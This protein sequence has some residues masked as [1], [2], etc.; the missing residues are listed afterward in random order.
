MGY[1]GSGWLLT[2]M[3][4]MCMHVWSGWYSCLLG[5]FKV[6][7]NILMRD[8]LRPRTLE[9]GLISGV[10][11][12]G[13]RQWMRWDG[14]GC[15]TYLLFYT[16]SCLAQQYWQSSI[17]ACTYLDID[18]AWIQRCN[19]HSPRDKN[20]SIL[21]QQKKSD[22]S[23]N[24]FPATVHTDM[25]SVLLNQSQLTTD[26]LATANYGIWYHMHQARHTEWTAWRECRLLEFI[27]LLRTCCVVIFNVI[28]VEVG[29]LV[30]FGSRIAEYGLAHTWRR[31][32]WRWSFDC[33]Q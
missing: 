28:I 33:K 18:M 29:W 14:I 5:Y 9:C 22:P 24:F 11:W 6:R 3:Y 26:Q 2:D 8:I 30:A 19:S 21:Y 12:L 17:Y 4:S 15:F 16:E 1:G 7:W 23:R 32:W 10:I 25:S 27:L 31:R 20:R 13:I